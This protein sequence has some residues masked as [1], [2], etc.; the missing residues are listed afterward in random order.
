MNKRRSVC[1]KLNANNMESYL[2]LGALFEATMIDRKIGDRPIT[3]EFSVG[4]SPK[5]TPTSPLVQFLKPRHLMMVSLFC[6][7]VLSLCDW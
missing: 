6:R 1:V 5:K 4:E 7:T 3:F 2:L